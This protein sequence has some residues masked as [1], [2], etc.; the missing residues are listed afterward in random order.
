MADLD[1]DEDLTLPPEEPSPFDF[2]GHDPD[3]LRRAWIFGLL[4]D[5]EIDGR[6]LVENMARVEL[7]LK[8]GNVEKEKTPLKVARA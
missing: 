2:C 8:T 1:D 3:Q 5:S 7:W 6:V 4:A